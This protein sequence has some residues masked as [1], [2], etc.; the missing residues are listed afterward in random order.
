MRQPLRRCRAAVCVAILLGGC[1]SPVPASSVTEITLVRGPCLGGCPD[2]T[3][4]LS[5][6][7]A[8]TFR[9]TRGVH[10]LGHWVATIDS[11]GFSQLAERV[12]A[13]GF[14]F[15]PTFNPPVGTDL[16]TAITCVRAAARWRC[17]FNPAAAPA[18]TLALNYAIDSVATRLKWRQLDTITVVPPN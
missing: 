1:H 11:L 3:F 2:Y 9:G 8:A 5:R 17:L 13:S 6:S 12:V 18:P 10:L 7:G 4:K 15:Q 14:F 16:P